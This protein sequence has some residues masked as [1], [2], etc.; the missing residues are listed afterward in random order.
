[1]SEFNSRRANKC[2]LS[3]ATAATD[4]TCMRRW[5]KTPSLASAQNNIE[6]VDAVRA[7]RYNNLQIS[8]R[9]THPFVCSGGP[10]NASE[11]EYGLI[12]KKV[13]RIKTYRQ[14]RSCRPIRLVVTKGRQTQGAQTHNKWDPITARKRRTN[15][16][17]RAG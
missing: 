11:I 10:T 2:N 7:G 1:M 6:D 14:H 16:Q 13:S 5:N 12:L 9:H 4:C 17:M 3:Q 15:K 8:Q